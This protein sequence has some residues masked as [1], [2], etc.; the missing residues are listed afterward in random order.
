MLLLKNYTRTAAYWLLGLAAAARVWAE[1]SG[2]EDDSFNR[3]LGLEGMSTDLANVEQELAHSNSP[4]SKPETPKKG[5]AQKNPPAKP[6]DS[7][8]NLS[9]HSNPGVTNT[10]RAFYVS[11]MNAPALVNAP[12]YDS[13][14]SRFDERFAN[15]GNA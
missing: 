4:A 7:F 1:E 3:S 14:R 15:Y 12:N 5:P 11:L 2:G 13:L 6:I 10:V 9:F 8:S